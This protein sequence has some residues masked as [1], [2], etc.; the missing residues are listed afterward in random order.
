MVGR[1]E[2]AIG[3][4]SLMGGAGL[5][6]G[7]LYYLG[8]SEALKPVT[9]IGSGIGRQIGIAPT[10]TPNPRPL[11]SDPDFSSTRG[12]SNDP[13]PRT[14]PPARNLNATGTP[15]RVK[16]N[17]LTLHRCPGYEC[18]TVTSLPFGTQVILLG[19]RDSSPGEEWCRVRAGKSE[20]WVSRYYLE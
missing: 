10:P 9:S 3:L 14:T 5:L 19:E 11:G 13:N 16:L 17:N 15:L 20:G 1:R 7:A 6:S 2:I 4:F 8:G 18:E 12:S